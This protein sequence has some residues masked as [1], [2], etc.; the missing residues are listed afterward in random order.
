MSDT[1]RFLKACRLEK[2]DFTPVWFMRQAGRYMPEYRKLREKHSLLEICK[3][4]E[5]AVEVTMQPVRALAVDAAI[6][7]ADIL[8]PLEG[9]GL[10]VEFSR[11]EGPVIL[12]PVR[13][14]SDVDAL[15][16]A[17]PE[18]HLGFVLKSIGGA[19][20]VLDG[21]VPLIGFGGAPFT[22]ASYMIEGGG[23]RNYLRTKSLMYSDPDAWNLM[24]AK[25]ADTLSRYLLAQVHAGAQAIQVFDSWVGCLS[26]A[27]YNQ[28]VLAHSSSLFRALRQGG[29]PTIHFGTGTADLLP[30]MREAGGDVMSIDWRT[31]LDHAWA[32]IGERCA[33]QGNLDPITLMAPWPLLKSRAQ[34]IL[35]RA[36]GR[37]GHIF[38]LGHGIL[39]STLVDA[40]KR[41]VDFVHDH[42]A[43]S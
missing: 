1:P 32:R 18:E 37:P 30:L 4:P 9:M 43:R 34:D 36:A 31:N 27:D 39:P 19:R 42:S 15:R 23:S 41:L 38:N 20:A 13:T 14:R 17:D 6:I 28:Y 8:L 16:L 40:V 22:L 11:E 7:F 26:P 24:M 5:L 25:L 35:D 2:A 33:I 12:N 3:T 10:E 21:K 29:V